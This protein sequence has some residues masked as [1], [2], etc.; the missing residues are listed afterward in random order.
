MKVSTEMKVESYCFGI[1][2]RDETLIEAT[3]KNAKNVGALVAQRRK[4]IM[5][6]QKLTYASDPLLDWDDMFR[7]LSMGLRNLEANGLNRFFE[8]NTFYRVPVVKGKVESRG[9]VLRNAVAFQE[10]KD[11]GKPFLVEVPEPFTFVSLC[12]DL[13]YGNKVALALDYAKAMNR[14]LASMSDPK[15]KLLVL[16]A[17]S[18]AFGLGNDD[19][20]LLKESL[21]VMLSGL[22]VTAILHLYFKDPSS[23]LKKL[24]GLPVSGLGL[25]LFCGASLSLKGYPYDEVALSAVDGRNTK[26]EKVPEM[27]GRVWALASEAKV[28]KLYVTNNSDL[29]LLPYVFAV[30]KL[31]VLTKVHRAVERWS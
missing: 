15:F 13:H 26:L 20:Q 2:P 14:E 31:A 29:E 19:L 8:T 12:S 1:F 21:K 16:K 18:C 22:K 23:V 30:R 17:P 24:G 7:P 27:A 11:V 5:G 4:K 6:L 10:L 3:R 9:D 25:D 28:K